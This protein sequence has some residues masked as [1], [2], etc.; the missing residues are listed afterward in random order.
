MG[1]DTV[2][3]DVEGKLDRTCENMKLNHLLTSDT[4]IH[5]GW[6]AHSNVSLEAIKTLEG[7]ISLSNSF[8][9]LSP[10]SRTTKAKVNKWNYFKLKS[11]CTVK[12]TISY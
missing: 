9:D 7:N 4:K 3:S 11:F 5:S 2:F 12:K 8:L 6:I 1:N 10:W